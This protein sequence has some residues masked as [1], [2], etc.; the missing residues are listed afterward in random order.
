MLHD[1]INSTKVQRAITAALGGAVLMSLV[2]CAATAHADELE[3]SDH[4]LT[5][6]PDA[7][8][9]TAPWT[10][11]AG[12]SRYDTMSAIVSEGWNKTGETQRRVPWAVVATGE[13]Y[14]DALAAS[15]VAGSANNAPIIL[16]KAHELSSQA[17]EQLRRLKVENVYLMGGTEAV[18]Q[19]VEQAIEDLQ[20]KVT[21]VAGESREQTS[22]EAF[23]LVRERSADSIEAVM[24]TTGKDYADALSAGP[25]AYSSHIPIV[26]ANEDGVLTEA[27]KTAIKGT[28]GLQTVYLLGGSSAVSS[29][30]QDQLGEGYTYV[31]FG[32]KDRYQ[33]SSIIAR[34]MVE[35]DEQRGIAPLGHAWT[36]PMVATGQ[37]FPDALSAS[38]LAGKNKGV[39]LLADQSDEDSI[40][41]AKTLAPGY[42]VGGEDVLKLE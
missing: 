14:P 2:A 41:F 7:A 23:K 13:N 24:V 40:E 19:S 37:N 30:V 8:E 4:V 35:G 29:A 28:E 1:H 42:L 38:A 18:D 33:T 12:S 11:L 34:A 5:T 39:L 10:R 36:M 25:L 15:A 3:P 32:G 26:L 17:R 16:T 6:T 27:E 31:R 20:I 22:L 9:T 21:R